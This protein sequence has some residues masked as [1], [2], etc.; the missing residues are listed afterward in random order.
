MCHNHLK[1]WGGEHFHWN[2][3]SQTSTERTLKMKMW[4]KSEFPL[5]WICCLFDASL[6]P[7]APF[8]R[9]CCLTS[10]IWCDII[11]SFIS[12]AL[13]ICKIHCSSSLLCMTP[14][15]DIYSR[16]ISQWLPASRPNL[17]YLVFN[18]GFGKS[19]SGSDK[20]VTNAS[21]MSDVCGRLRDCRTSGGCENSGCGDEE[22]KRRC[23]I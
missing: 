8:C 15:L 9:C 10:W 17:P 7:A 19:L 13:L 22:W 5:G 11:G 18:A 3:S 23:R 4:I 12:D 1:W 21:V 6:H 16:L 2:N 14:T 20:N